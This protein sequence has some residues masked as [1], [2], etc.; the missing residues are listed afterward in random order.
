VG[1]HK[2]ECLHQELVHEDEFWKRLPVSRIQV[3]NPAISIYGMREYQVNDCLS[4][5]KEVVFLV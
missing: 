4:R 2:V 5:S 3:Q 1:L